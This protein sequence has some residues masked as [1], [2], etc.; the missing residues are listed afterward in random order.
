MKE[1]IF[2]ISTLLSSLLIL[3][4]L[5]AIFYTLVSRSLP[6]FQEFGVFNFIFSSEWISDPVSENYGAWSFIC[7]T[8]LVS[9]LAILFSIPFTLSITLF[10]VGLH[11]HS[12]LSKY[13][14][15]FVELFAYTPA[16]IFAVWGHY[17]LRELF[18]SCNIG[19]FGYGILSTAILLTIMVIPFASS[20]SIKCLSGLPRSIQERAYSLGATKAETAG[21]ITLPYAAKGIIG[22]HLLALGKVFGEAIVVTTLIGNSIKV[23][24]SL[25]DTGSSMSSIIVNQMGEHSSELKFSVL[26]AILL[27][28]F[29]LSAGTNYIGKYF[30]EKQRNRLK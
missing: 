18:I 13:V 8:L 15:S 5:I 21:K 27:L 3:I 14:N 4:L 19:T 22:S 28:L 1:K 23:P 29:I 17:S 9:F 26:M 12:F 2:N 16:V 24:S 10:V 11:K 6:A 20:M 30:I 7:G 25:T